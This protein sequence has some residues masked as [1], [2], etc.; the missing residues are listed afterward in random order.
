MSR[1]DPT[2]DKIVADRKLQ[3]MAIHR[4]RLRAGLGLAAVGVALALLLLWLSVLTKKSDYSRVLLESFG[5][6]LLAAS[7]IEVLADLV[8]RWARSE[9]APATE[10][11][12][13]QRFI[14]STIG[15]LDAD[16][17]NLDIEW[18][19]YRD[20]QQ[21]HA[22]QEAKVREAWRAYVRQKLTS[23]ELRLLV[24][25]IEGKFPKQSSE[26][27]VVAEFESN[28]QDAIIAAALAA[29]M[30]GQGTTPDYGAR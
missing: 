9:D 11:I 16:L 19:A 15:D 8:A 2:F 24:D 23:S 5:V 21:N 28:R 10:F 1:P 6:A 25:A 20:A 17:Q 14:L 3:E 29:E 4:H 22:R 13:V 7:S 27:E 30:S 12:R 18:R 26:D